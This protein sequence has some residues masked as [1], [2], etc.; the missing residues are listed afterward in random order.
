MGAIVIS[1]ALLLAVAQVAHADIEITGVL[2]T[3]SHTVAIDMAQFIGDSIYVFP[4]PGWQGDSMVL[5]TFAFPPM[6]GPPQIVMLSVTLDGSPL[7]VTLPPPI[8]SDTWYLIPSTPQEA[9]VEFIWGAGGV[10]AQV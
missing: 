3:G 4:T 6:F 7:N 8:Q 10:G 5:D 1:T 9:K 2:S